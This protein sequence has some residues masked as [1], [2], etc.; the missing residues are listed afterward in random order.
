VGPRKFLRSKTWRAAIRAEFLGALARTTAGATLVP[1][2]A[3]LVVQ[4]CGDY[5]SLLVECSGG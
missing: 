5:E 1:L 4:S 2:C 3:L